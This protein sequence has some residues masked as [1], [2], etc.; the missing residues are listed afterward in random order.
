MRVP[1]P[2]QDT[3]QLMSELRSMSRMT[4]AHEALHASAKGHHKAA[5][6]LRCHKHGAVTCSKVERRALAAQNNHTHKQ[7]LRCRL[8]TCC[9]C[10]CCCCCW[11]CCQHPDRVLQEAR[12]RLMRQGCESGPVLLLTSNPGIPFM[13][14]TAIPLVPSGQLMRTP[15]PSQPSLAHPTH[16]LC[17]GPKR[18]GMTHRH[19]CKTACGT[20]THCTAPGFRRQTR[21]TQAWAVP[22]QCHRCDAS[23]DERILPQGEQPQATARTCRQLHMLTR[24]EPQT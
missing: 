21:A 18:H 22:R 13:L 24:Q 23:A 10:C 11:G 20:A 2:T 12:K 19:T 5:A 16:A 6:A 3:T 14:H 8:G 17:R 1:I 15:R 4:G 7:C 9:H